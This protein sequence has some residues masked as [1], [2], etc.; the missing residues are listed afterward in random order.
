MVALQ[1]Y[2]RYSP[3]QQAAFLAAAAAA[4]EAAWWVGDETPWRGA[5]WTLVL[6]AALAPVAVHVQATFSGGDGAAVALVGGW[7][8]PRPGAQACMGMFPPSAGVLTYGVPMAVAVMLAA[9][10]HNA[11]WWIAATAIQGCARFCIMAQKMDR[12]ELSHSIPANFIA[13]LHY[14]WLCTLA[15][16]LHVAAA[17]AVALAVLALLQ[18]RRRFP[19]RWETIEWTIGFPPAH[20]LHQD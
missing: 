5:V 12:E 11:A 7:A 13:H 19:S 9:Q 16:G 18:P 15:M 17:T 4:A 6:A 10:G 3:G 2:V 14:A 20:L 8:H 1:T